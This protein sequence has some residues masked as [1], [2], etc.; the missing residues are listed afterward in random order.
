MIT[1]RNLI[2][3]KTRIC[4]LKLSFSCISRLTIP[5]NHFFAT[6][7]SN[8]DFPSFDA[9]KQI[10]I[11]FS[12]DTMNTLK[13]NEI[14]EFNEIQTKI[15]QLV[16]ARKNLIGKN[17]P[18]NESIFSFIV[19]I[20][21]NLRKQNQNEPKLRV[22]IL[23]PNLESTR[24]FRLQ[25]EQFYN[26][27]H[28]FNTI[29]LGQAIKTQNRYF[30]EEEDYDI[31]ISSPTEFL[32]FITKQ[33]PSFSDL[34][35]L[36]I[37]ESDK[38]ETFGLNNIMDQTLLT[39]KK[40]VI[41]SEKEFNEVQISIFTKEITDYLQ[42]VPKKLTTSNFEIVDFEVNKIGSVSENQNFVF[43]SND[44]ISL[45]DSIKKTMSSVSKWNKKMVVILNSKTDIEILRLQTSH[46]KTISFIISDTFPHESAKKVTDF[47]NGITSCLI[48]SAGST[49]L[50][51]FNTLDLVVYG[52]A[53]KNDH[54][55]KKKKNYA[56]V[57][58]T[59][60]SQFNQILQIENA[61]L[62]QFHRIKKLDDFLKDLQKK[63]AP[64]DSIENDQKKKKLAEFTFS[65]KN[66]N[67]KNNIENILHNDGT[68]KTD[69]KLNLL[70][71]KLKETDSKIGEYEDDVD[72]NFDEDFEPISENTDSTHK[73]SKHQPAV[74][75]LPETMSFS[76][77]FT[78][79]SFLSDGIV[80]P[81]LQVNS[82]QNTKFNLKSSYLV[83]FKTS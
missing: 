78:Q 53:P 68:I 79:P 13:K 46:L 52:D 51:N 75:A 17:M 43:Q 67:S 76:F 30:E 70:K 11:K 77:D 44:K 32:N 59:L 65:A 25:I 4:K 2:Q 42:D 72:T 55:F 7:N 19:P 48:I 62:A 24:K 26:F 37:L 49:S 56:S 40:A 10:P 5:S 27:D 58:C 1:I 54:D 20:L 35:Y 3:K 29:S 66:A 63:I 8:S 33:S 64:S 50:I 47:N 61:G 41:E 74:T 45:L 71:N 38:F 15:A 57:F 83:T 6:L 23:T 81:K 9:R 73:K 31:V 12:K 39:L 36:I 14:V 80:K 28:E 34:Q 69:D 18:E 82:K 60:A 22:L 16:T 21:E